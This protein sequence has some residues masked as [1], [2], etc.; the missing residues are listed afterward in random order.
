MIREDFAPFHA[1]WLLAHAKSSSNQIPADAVIMSVFD[2]LAP[3]PLAAVEAA[4]RHHARA[5]RF[6]PTVH[7]VVALLEAANQRLSADEAWALMPRS[8]AETICWTQEM[9]AAYSVAQPLL[10]IGEAYNAGLAFKAAYIRQCKEAEIQQK[11]VVWRVSLGTDKSLARS[12]LRQ[13]VAL[14]R[15]SQAVADRLLPGAM[16]G[17]VI[18]GLLTGG[19]AAN[20]EALADLPQ[21]WRQIRQSLVTGG[22]KWG[23]QRQA[24]AEPDA[25]VPGVP[26]GASGMTTESG[27]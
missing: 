7:D 10:A 24:L 12:A 5:S 20:Q 22:F 9:A 16:D 4:L 15:I 2:D 19:A 18:A 6:A 21:R 26:E 3:Y 13:A 14:G 11:P 27:R 23:G 25:P 17:G 8:E 1:L